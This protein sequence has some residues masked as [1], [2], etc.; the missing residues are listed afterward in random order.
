[1][2]MNTYVRTFVYTCINIQKKLHLWNYA[3][4]CLETSWKTLQ[5]APPPKKACYH[6]DLDLLETGHL[7]VN[8][9]A[10]A[11]CTCVCWHR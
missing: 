8:W 10:A 4:L 9:L 11:A 3:D 6:S 7:Y 1:M 5:S 2:Y